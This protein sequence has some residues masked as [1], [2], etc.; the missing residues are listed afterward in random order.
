VSAPFQDRHIGTDAAAQRTM[1][2]ALGYDS[3]EA[4]VTA[5]VPDAI[6]VE[7]LES[8]VI[9]PAASEREALARTA[10]TGR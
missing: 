1:L 7:P 2:S 9:P 8:S 5:A 4:L 6:A 3:V 10:S